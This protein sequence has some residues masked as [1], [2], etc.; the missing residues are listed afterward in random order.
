MSPAEEEDVIIRGM[1]ERHALG[2]TSIRELAVWPD[3]VQAYYRVWRQGKLTGRVAL[4]IEF[5]D[6]ANTARNLELMGVAVP[7]GDHWLRMDSSGEEPWIPGVMAK[8]PYTELMLTL[9]RLGWRP[10]PHVSADALRGINYDD[11]TNQTLDAYEAADRAAPIREKRWYIEHVPFATPEQVD[12]MAKLRL[13]VSIQDSGYYAALSNYPP[14]KER[15][16]HQN[17]VRSFLDRG[18]VV[19]GGSDY[20]GPMAGEKT[21]NNP[22][23]PFSF[24]VTRKAKDGM[25]CA[26]AEKISRQEAL[27]IFTANPGYATFEEK[28]KGIIEPGKL[29]DFV[30]LSQDLMTVPDD[31]ILEITALATFVG[32]KKVYSAPGSRF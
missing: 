2:I 19:V 28:A 4:G 9:N 23:I 5:P 8:Q 6:P 27:R 11:S 16:D 24:Y 1:K 31:K 32:G 25:L 14:E 29:A 7:F 26:P 22:L 10:T 21:P 3:A 20:N 13:I 18:L 17:P 30:I 15:R 12:R